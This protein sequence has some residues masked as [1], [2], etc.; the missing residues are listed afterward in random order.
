MLVM[1]SLYDGLNDI[2]LSDS[3]GPQG[4]DF[5]NSIVSL[6]SAEYCFLMQNWHLKS[7]VSL[8]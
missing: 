1:N 5:Q 7:V 6:Q 2:F 3:N 4:S 8:R